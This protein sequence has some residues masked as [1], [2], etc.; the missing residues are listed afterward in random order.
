MHTQA[1]EPLTVDPSKVRDVDP[2]YGAWI[3]SKKANIIV[4]FLVRGQW[5]RT[6]L[7][8]LLRTND[9]KATAH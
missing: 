3:L 7:S 5:I 8:S 2:R 6:M 1:G 9:V 4:S